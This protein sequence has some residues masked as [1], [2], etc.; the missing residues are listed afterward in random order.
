[1]TTWAGGQKH[2]ASLIK[3]LSDPMRKHERIP[4][5]F[6]ELGR[7]RGGEH[8]RPLA[9]MNQAWMPAADTCAH[10]FAP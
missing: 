8:F 6:A 4:Q 10:D 5:T 7:K 9:C 1:M 3:A 2:S